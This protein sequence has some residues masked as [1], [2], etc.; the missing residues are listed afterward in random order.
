M[1]RPS[2]LPSPAPAAATG[3]AMAS[4][5]ATPAAKPASRQPS[6]APSRASPTPSETVEVDYRSVVIAVIT[7]CDHTS[8]LHQYHA[9]QQLH[10]AVYRSHTKRLKDIFHNGT[11]IKQDVEVVCTFRTI[12]HKSAVIY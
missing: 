8:C 5:G 4:T 6:P 9:V 7:A 11:F 12:A 2:A 1:K 3:Q 10:K